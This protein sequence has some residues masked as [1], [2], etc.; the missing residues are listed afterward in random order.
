MPEA[1]TLLCFDV[2]ESACEVEFGAKQAVDR[3]NELR[4][5]WSWLPGTT[6]GSWRGSYLA[7][8]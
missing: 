2:L 8:Q 1:T 7:A 5:E 3:R 4:L 6:G